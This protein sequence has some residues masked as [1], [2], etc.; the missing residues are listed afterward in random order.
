MRQ[1]ERQREKEGEKKGDYNE[2]V[3]RMKKKKNK[4]TQPNEY[5]AMKSP[6]KYT[7]I[8]LWNKST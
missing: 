6:F 3:E 4:K 7:H 2:D 1:R 8:S 5:K